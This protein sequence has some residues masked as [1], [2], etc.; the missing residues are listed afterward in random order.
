MRH[1][2]QSLRFDPG[3]VAGVRVLMETA[4]GPGLR[5]KRLAELERQAVTFGYP[6]LA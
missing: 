1:L 5:F 3:R 4:K 2:R 6:A